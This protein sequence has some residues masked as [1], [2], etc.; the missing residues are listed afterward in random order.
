VGLV[1]LS[2]VREEAS[3]VA[4]HGRALLHAPPAFAREGAS[5]L[6]GYRWALLHS[7]PAFAREGRRGWGPQ[8]GLVVRTHQEDW[9]PSAM[10]WYPCRPGEPKSFWNEG[11]ANA[12]GKRPL[13]SAR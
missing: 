3:E 5:G 10:W 1:A 11:G 8:A 4:G 12:G 13:W 2:F 7:P 6:G 9:S